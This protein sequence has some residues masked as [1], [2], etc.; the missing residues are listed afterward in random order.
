MKT[1][2]LVQVDVTHLYKFKY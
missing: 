2:Q 1:E